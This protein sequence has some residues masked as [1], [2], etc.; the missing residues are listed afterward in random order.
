MSEFGPDELIAMLD[1]EWGTAH[2]D[3]VRAL[4]ARVAE[5]EGALRQL[6]HRMAVREIPVDDEIWWEDDAMALARAR[7]ALAKGET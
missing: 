1:E 3:V 7:A 6:T 4:R 5:L 2:G